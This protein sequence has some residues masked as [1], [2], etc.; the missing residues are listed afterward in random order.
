MYNYEIR[1][2][3]DKTANEGALKSGRYLIN[4]LII[5]SRIHL[6]QWRKKQWKMHSLTNER[7]MQNF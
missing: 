6:L 4:L 1:I 5:V 2:T 7:S 3:L